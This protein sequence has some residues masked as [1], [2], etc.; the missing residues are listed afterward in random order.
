MY[1]INAFGAISERKAK[2]GAKIRVPAAL[3]ICDLAETKKLRSDRIICIKVLWH[4][5]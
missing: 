4:D 5:S 1:T 3:T 2:N